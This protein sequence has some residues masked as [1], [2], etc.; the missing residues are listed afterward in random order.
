MFNNKTKVKNQNRIFIT[1]KTQKT[2]LKGR[3]MLTAESVIW[4]FVC[5]F[6]MC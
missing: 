6:I 3:D 2:V 5:L 1:F 4:R